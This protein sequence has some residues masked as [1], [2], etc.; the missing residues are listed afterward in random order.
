MVTLFNYYGTLLIT[1]FLG[2]G[3]WGAVSVNGVQRVR[4]ARPHTKSGKGWHAKQVC[5]VF[6]QVYEK[7]FFLPCIFHP[8]SLLSIDITIKRE[9]AIINHT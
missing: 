2:E 7:I 1:I 9:S 4:R 8:I 6:P 5:R 3:G